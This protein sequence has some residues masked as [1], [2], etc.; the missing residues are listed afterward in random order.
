MVQAFQLRE[1]LEA[2]EQR[3]PGHPLVATF[4]PVLLSNE[5]TLQ[6]HAVEY[7]QRIEQ[8]PLAAPLKEALIEVFIDW[9]WQ[10]FGT[11]SKKEIEAMILGDI[12]HL[13]NTRAGQELIAEGEEQG[14]IKAIGWYLT[15]QHGRVPERIQQRLAQLPLPTLQELA[16]LV[17]QGMPLPQLDAWL[18]EHGGGS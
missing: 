12:T 14:L 4:Q 18:T 16:P 8:S 3:Q 2:L 1:V 5:A 6:A 13:K 7:Y 17:F 9:L 15:A 11:L 10:R